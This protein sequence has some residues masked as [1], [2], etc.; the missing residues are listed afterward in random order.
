MTLLAIAGGLLLALALIAREVQIARERSALADQVERQ[1]LM[2]ADTRR[3]LRRALE[4]L[5]V[6]QTLLAD[7]HLLDENEFA[8]GRVRLIEKPRRV[9]E[10]RNA[11]LRDSDVEPTQLVVDDDVNKIH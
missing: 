7:K 11:I 10:E 5:Y 1:R 6:M 2:A 9:A 8:R 4:D 3:Q